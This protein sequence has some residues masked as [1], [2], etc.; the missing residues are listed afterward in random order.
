MTMGA[1]KYC[2]WK[3][4]NHDDPFREEK[5]HHKNKGRWGCGY[6]PIRLKLENTSIL[7]QTKLKIS[8]T[9]EINKK[10]RRCGFLVNFAANKFGPNQLLPKVKVS[11]DLEYWIFSENIIVGPLGK[12]GFSV[13]N[14]FPENFR[15]AFEPLQPLF[16]KKKKNVAI[17]SGNLFICQKNRNKIFQIGNDPPNRNR[18]FSEN[19]SISENTDFP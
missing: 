19:S 16:W 2:G 18:K 15:K 7:N 5:N 6:T 3:D 14:E 1:V 10:L 13:M 4:S 8:K 9:Q 12:P 17:F 11:Q